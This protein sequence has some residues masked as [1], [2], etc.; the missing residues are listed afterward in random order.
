M[1][2]V[3]AYGLDI[4]LVDDPFVHLADDS[5][6]PLIEAIVPGAFLV[7]LIPA[8]RYV[9]AWFPGASF[10]R[11]AKEWKKMTMVFRNIPY[12]AAKQA[13]VSCPSV[14]FESRLMPY[15]ACGKG[16]A[17]IH[18]DVSRSRYPSKPTRRRPH[19]RYRFYVLC[20]YVDAAL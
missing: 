19:P 5:M 8:L 1:T 13:I 15:L 10:Q 6:R 16:K 9:P 12:D 3:L 11:K 4:K 17:L 7:D 2:L 18:F 20:R 14:Y